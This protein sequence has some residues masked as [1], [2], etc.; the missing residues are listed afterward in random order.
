VDE[1]T[2][3]AEQLF[4]TIGTLRVEVLGRT[5]GAIPF[6]SDAQSVLDDPL[7]QIGPLARCRRGPFASLRGHVGNGLVEGRF[8]E[9]DMILIP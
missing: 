1:D 2:Y 4:A 6:F 5:R 7:Q 8:V 3:A 9:F